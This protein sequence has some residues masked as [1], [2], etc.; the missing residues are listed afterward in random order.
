GALTSG[1]GANVLAVL[2]ADREDYS[3]GD[4]VEVLPFALAQDTIWP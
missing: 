2:P 1:I 4:M 3:P